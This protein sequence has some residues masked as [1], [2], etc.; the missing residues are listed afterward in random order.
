[1]K[2]FLGVIAAA[3]FALCSLTNA[4]AV[5]CTSLSCTL[6]L[7]DAGALNQGPL[8]DGAGQSRT[9]DI[10]TNADGNLIV[11]I[12]SNGVGA[13]TFGSTLLKLGATT[14]GATLDTSTSTSVALVFANLAAGV[15]SLIVPFGVSG[16]GNNAGYHGTATLLSASVPLPPSLPLLG[17]A[18][19][20][21]AFV[22][23]RKR[24]RMASL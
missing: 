23:Y 14:I 20:L 4:Q 18:L 8:S 3:L 13:L 15:Y 6:S 21:L 16:G 1:M 24:R 9:Y 12:D 19:G 5:D 22:M 17:A 11:S 7:G 10:T 2:H